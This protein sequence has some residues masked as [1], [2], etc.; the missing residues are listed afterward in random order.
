[1][2]SGL[3]C[4]R[5][6]LASTVLL[7]LA[8]PIIARVGSFKVV[9]SWRSEGVVLDIDRPLTLSIER[10]VAFVDILGLYSTYRM[11]VSPDGGYIYVLDF[12]VPSD[13]PQAFIQDCNVIWHKD[14]IEFVMPSGEAMAIPMKT[15]MRQIGH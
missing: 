1:M 5:I 15:V 4:G 7:L 13:K 2:R 11:V 10:H 9:R 12:E 3:S 6:L 14:K 8:A